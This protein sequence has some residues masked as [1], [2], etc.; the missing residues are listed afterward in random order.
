[1][2]GHT[3]GI[4]VFAEHWGEDMESIDMESYVEQYQAAYG[5]VTLHTWMDVGGRKK[6][7]FYITGTPGTPVPSWFREMLRQKHLGDIILFPYCSSGVSE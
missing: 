5:E 1:V 2:C 6:E 7:N 4:S 3:D